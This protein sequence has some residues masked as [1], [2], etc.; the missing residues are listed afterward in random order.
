M[1]PLIAETYV[2]ARRMALAQERKK[3]RIAVKGLVDRVVAKAEVSSS[4]CS[5][6]T[7]QGNFKENYKR[8]KEEEEEESASKNIFS[9]GPRMQSVQLVLPSHANHMNNTF[10]GQVMEWMVEASIIAAIRHVKQMVRVQSIDH[11]YFVAPSKV[12]DRIYVKAQV[13]RSFGGSMEV[14]VRAEAVSPSSASAAVLICKMFAFIAIIGAGTNNTKVRFNDIPDVSPISADEIRRWRAARGR[15]Q[16]RLERRALMESGSST[17]Q[18]A[19][20]WSDNLTTQE[21]RFNNISALLH[22]ASTPKTHWQTI[23]VNGPLHLE[24][25]ETVDDVTAVKLCA[26]IE[27]SASSTFQFL[28]EIQNRKLWDQFFI[29]AEIRMSIADEDD[30]LWLAMGDNDFCLLRSWTSNAPLDTN[31]VVDPSLHRYVIACHSVIHKSTPANWNPVASSKV[32]SS[33]LEIEEQYHL[34]LGDEG[35]SLPNRKSFVR[36]EVDSSGFIIEPVRLADGSYSSDPSQCSLTY[37]AQ[38]G[39]SALRLVIG[40][41]YTDRAAEIS[42]SSPRETPSLSSSQRSPLLASFVT[43]REVLAARYKVERESKS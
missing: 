41:L 37:I 9:T 28:K 33:G 39:A 27:A 29:D 20:T 5:T 30:I 3:I 12:G 31:Q 24:L 15:Q 7:V 21:F 26:T 22:L 18:V 42:P 11:V 2:E 23:A 43:L 40:E 16:I 34:S 38:I 17:K 4:F 13:N 1:R 36:S 19:W 10:G 32:D 25:K 14:G 35:L 6:I 8:H